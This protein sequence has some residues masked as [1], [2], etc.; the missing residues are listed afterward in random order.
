MDSD[1]VDT[2]LELGIKCF[3]YQEYQKAI[4]L[5]GKALKLARSYSDDTLESMRE[6]LGIRKR[7]LHDPNRTYHPRYLILLDNR[8]ASWERINNLGKAL[9]DADRMIKVD[10]YNLKG[11]IRKG[12]ILQ[13]MAQDKEA[14]YVYREGLS[15]AKEAY[16]LH[17]EK[18]P[19]KFVEIVEHQKNEVIKRLNLQKLTPTTGAS[20]RTHIEAIQPEKL[21]KSS[22]ANL[23]STMS[24]VRQKHVKVDF[25]SLLPLEVVFL[26][27]SNLSTKNLVRCLCVSKLWYHRL[28][29]LP[30]LFMDFELSSC[31][32]RKLLK[33]IK[34]MNDL[35]ASCRA[36]YCGKINFGALKLTE[37]EKSFIYLLSNLKLGPQQ[38]IMQ[39]NNFTME[40]I[41]NLLPK[42][43]RLIQPVKRLSIAAPVR[44]PDGIDFSKFYERALSLVD[45]ELL[46]TFLPLER[47]A[48]R[49]QSIPSTTSL[50]NVKSF[51]LLARQHNDLHSSISDQFLFNTPFTKL[52]KLYV[53]GVVFNQSTSTSSSWITTLPNLRE[54][55][56]ERNLGIRFQNVLKYMVLVAGPKRL[57]KL[58]FRESPSE[59]SILDN[60][61]TQWLDINIIQDLFKDL[62]VLDVMNTKFDPKILLTILTCVKNGKLKRLNI[63]NCPSLSFSRDLAIIDEILQNIV[64]VEELQ[65]PNLMEFN[66]YSI[67]VL[68]KNIKYINSLKKLDLSFN[69][70]LKGYELIDLMREI[71]DKELITLESLAIDGC[72]DVSPQAVGYVVKNNYCKK[73]TCIYEKKQWEIFGVNSFWYK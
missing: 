43:H 56:M 12:K 55:W 10:A 70:G 30:K 17:F 32:Y 4:G 47:E 35:R 44:R 65:L 23:C 25:V 41:L 59:S 68:R 48:F 72:P 9:I 16:Q 66:Q 71:K 46:L 22:H 60:D 18:P 64:S 67:S 3:Q 73:V 54:I 61:I 6:N 52:T 14:L 69:N 49:P 62:I 38:L 13:K 11:Y 28:I 45:L 31:D 40:A 51:K 33:C 37:E 42:N 50:L 19:S 39:S 2:T 26:I 15:K 57:Q 8:A 20:K 27:M 36:I 34:F 58:T 29:I 21:K 1:L 63:G 7:C 5:F 53:T 24:K